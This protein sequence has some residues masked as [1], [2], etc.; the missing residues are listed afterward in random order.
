MNLEIAPPVDNQA[1][2]KQYNHI[3]THN[4]ACYKR[5]PVAVG[6]LN[7]TPMLMVWKP[8]LR[9]KKGTLRCKFMKPDAYFDFKLGLQT[10]LSLNVV[11][12]NTF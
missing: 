8:S 12:V 6:S 7:P 1:A 10:G 9:Y 5:G 11:L 2:Y 3:Y 4:Q